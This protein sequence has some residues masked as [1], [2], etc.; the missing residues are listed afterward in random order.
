MCHFFAVE[1]RHGTSLQIFGIRI[2]K[3]IVYLHFKHKNDNVMKKAFIFSLMCLVALAI[4]AQNYV[5]LGLTSGT[6]WKDQNEKGYYTYYKAM[7]LFGDEMPTKAQWEELVKE[8]K[9]TWLG[10]AYKVV[11]PNGK[12]ITIPAEGYFPYV[13]ERTSIVV[14]NGNSGHYWSATDVDEL[15]SSWYL[16]FYSTSLEMKHNAWAYQQSV[17]LVKKK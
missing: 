9:W 7:N 3:K 17:R 6:Q 8:C 14:D 13:G 15:K 2:T 4:S 12:S 16:F 11:G 5:D 10:E 1:T